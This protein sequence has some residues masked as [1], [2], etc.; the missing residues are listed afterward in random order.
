[1]LLLHARHQLNVRAHSAAYASERAGKQMAL[2]SR[3]FVATRNKL[4]SYEIIVNSHHRI[5]V[6][7]GV[8]VGIVSV[9]VSAIFIIH[10][11][12]SFIVGS[13]RF[14]LIVLRISTT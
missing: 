5:Y 7:I 9:S 12:I 2:M 4:P 8:N 11:S 6:A 10:Y 3:Y 14:E 1:M 13:F